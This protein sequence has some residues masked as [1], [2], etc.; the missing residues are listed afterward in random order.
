M[1]IGTY[2][3][4]LKDINSPILKPLNDN[5]VYLIDPE[6]TSIKDGDL[7]FVWDSKTNQIT[8]MDDYDLLQYPVGLQEALR[9]Y[10][11]INGAIDQYNRAMLAQ[12]IKD[13]MPQTAQKKKGGVLKAK[14]GI[15]VP[16]LSSLPDF[17]YTGD[18]NAIWRE[19]LSAGDV[20]SWLEKWRKTGDFGKPYASTTAGNN[21]TRY[22]PTDNK[23]GKEVEDIEKQAYYDWFSNPNNNILFDD[24]GNPTDQGI[25]WMKAVDKLLPEQNKSTFYNESGELRKSW[26]P[27]GIDARGKNTNREFN[28]AKEYADYLMHDQTLGARHN[29]LVR[30]GT[31]Y[32]YTGSDGK[33]HY[34]DPA[35]ANKY[36]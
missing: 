23:V 15:N 34:V 27:T 4:Y 17:T 25:A 13:N 26:N 9:Q 24:K 6:G 16:K 33:I 22:T 32:Y 21:D 11:D 28:T 8:E 18:K 35:I 1:G 7:S 12:Q 29:V 31:R 19:N 5:G 2:L 36:E 30:T 20:N 14:D 3:Q 10:Y